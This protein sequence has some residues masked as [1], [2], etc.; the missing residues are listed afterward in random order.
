MTNEQ[1]EVETKKLSEKLRWEQENNLKVCEPCMWRKFYH[2]IVAK[3]I[4][5]L[6]ITMGEL[7]AGYQHYSTIIVICED[8]CKKISIKRLSNVGKIA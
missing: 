1:L 6:G 8:C 2:E 3:P 4:C 7:C 5:E